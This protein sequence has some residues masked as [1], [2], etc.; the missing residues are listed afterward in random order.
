[1][2]VQRIEGKGEGEAVDKLEGDG[3]VRRSD[4][5]C[6]M[7]DV[8]RASTCK[9]HQPYAKRLVGRVSACAELPLLTDGENL[10]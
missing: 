4:V 2:L 10:G 1:M 9:G 7:I 3:M 5:W 6:N 8:V